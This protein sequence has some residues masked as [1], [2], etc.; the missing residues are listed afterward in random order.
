MNKSKVLINI[1]ENRRLQGYYDAAMMYYEDALN[2]TKELGNKLY[3]A[4]T[5]GNIGHIYKAKG[6]SDTAIV[7]YDRAI[8]ILRELEN[9]Y[10][11]CEC[12][13]GK[14]EVLFLPT[15][16]SKGSDIMHRRASNCGKNW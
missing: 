5:L 9:K 4:L 2:I 11:L 7:S 13:V 8:A 14:A 15:R 1:G 16:L 10:Y 6:N 3:I 12:L